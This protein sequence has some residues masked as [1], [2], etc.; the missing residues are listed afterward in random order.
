MTT[1]TINPELAELE[2]LAAENAALAKANQAI[3][4]IKARRAGRQRALD[5]KTLEQARNTLAERQSFYQKNHPIFLQQSQ[6]YDNG[7]NHLIAARQ[8]VDE[9]KRHQP[10]VAAYLPNDPEMRRWQKH[11][12]QLLARMA[13]A[14]AIFDALPDP[15]ASD[16][17]SPPPSNRS[18]RS[19]THATT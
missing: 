6:D 7:R 5:I 15:E 1:T 2:E 17:D 14:Q 12:D 10:T 16:K 19:P 18:S 4:E 11:H 8:V 13:D 9:S 3:A